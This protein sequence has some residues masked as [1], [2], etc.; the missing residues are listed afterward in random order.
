MRG[1]THA[2]TDTHPTLFGVLSGFQVNWACAGY[3]VV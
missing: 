1:K 2:H 3:G